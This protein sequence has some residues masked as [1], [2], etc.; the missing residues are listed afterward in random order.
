MRVLVLVWLIMLNVACAPFTTYTIDPTFMPYVIEFSQHVNVSRVT[1][2]FGNVPEAASAACYKN[3]LG[4]MTINVR[5]T[6]W[7]ILCDKQKRALIF[8]ELGHCVLGRDHLDNLDSYMYPEIQDCN[9]YEL[10]EP[11]LIQ[12]LFE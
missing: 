10:N 7:N 11:Y 3:N 8:H 12:E 1:I 6:M 9:F 4:D 5:N 2:Q